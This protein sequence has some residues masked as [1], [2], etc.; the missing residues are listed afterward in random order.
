MP[1]IIQRDDITSLQVDGIVNAAN[2]HLSMG[3]GVCG[4]IFQKAGKSQLE[5]ACTALAPVKTG[6]A[7]IT[8][9]F[10]LPSTY[11]IHAVGPIYSQHSPE[12]SE[13]L[14]GQTYKEAL[15]IAKNHHMESVAFP[16]I[17]SGHYGFPKEK[18]LEIARK[19]ITSFLEQEDLLVY[20]T[21]FDKESF[22]LSESLLGPIESYIQ[23][24]YVELWEEKESSR[25]RDYE[26]DLNDLDVIEPLFS[27]EPPPVA[28]EKK[29]DTTNILRSASIVS[30]PEISHFPLPLSNATM[31]RDFFA[32]D[33]PFSVVL[34]KLID[35]KKKTDV[36]VY[37]KANI[38]RKLF[39]KIR[40][41][42]QYTPS[43]P[44]IL[45]LAIALE[46]NLDETT[47][48]LQC[49]G[50]AL[51][52]SRKFDVIVEYFITRSSYD[53]F[54]INE[55]LFQYDQVLLGK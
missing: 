9:G 12:E 28:I 1:L 35:Q 55:V 46:L 3:G 52:H 2:P 23:A 5:K 16:L 34:L 54:Q 18:A 44:T 36:E 45:A 48:L 37:K 8:S 14:L 10:Q 31:D 50:Y 24:N 13:T 51:S 26:E 11:I 22:T 7:V 32:V 49:A 47:D 4:A 30:A 41:V 40:T 19:T 17:S 25:R 38:D 39:S 21:I 27:A 42:P 53:I 15:E 29:T 6:S 20:L 43:K 33:E